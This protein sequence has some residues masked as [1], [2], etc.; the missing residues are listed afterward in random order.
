MFVEAVGTELAG[1][2]AGALGGLD[3]MCEPAGPRSGLSRANSCPVPGTGG[4]PPATASGCREEAAP[5]ACRE[6]GAPIGGW[7]MGGRANWTPTAQRMSPVVGHPGGSR[8]TRGGWRS[9]GAWRDRE[10]AA[11]R[12]RASR[13]RGALRRVRRGTPCGRAADG[14]EEGAEKRR[15]IRGRVTIIAGGPAAPIHR[16][17]RG[18]PRVRGFGGRDPR[19]HPLPHRG[20]L[21]RW[22]RRRLQ[23]PRGRVRAIEGYRARSGRSGAA[24]TSA[25]AAGSVHPRKDA[26]GA[27]L[28]PPQGV[29]GPPARDVRPSKAGGVEHLSIKLISESHGTSPRGK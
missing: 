4:S 11:T 13:G 3:P 7:P 15:G 29:R 18:S 14:V 23:D 12:S 9:P 22:I 24:P 6:R 26:P 8:R 5:R 16:G 1:L 27:A 28:T 19:G 25:Q 17:S 10:G 20:G 21:N 2:E